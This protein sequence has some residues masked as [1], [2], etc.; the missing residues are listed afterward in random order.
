MDINET[1]KISTL[2]MRSTVDLEL[3]KRRLTDSRN[4]RIDII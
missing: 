4:D 2:E 1:A 3:Y